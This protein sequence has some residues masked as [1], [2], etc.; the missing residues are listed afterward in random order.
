MK[1]LGIVIAF[2]GRSGNVLP[3]A[4]DYKYSDLA[5]K[6]TSISCGTATHSNTGF[7]ASQCSLQ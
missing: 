7:T 2:N 6:P 5:N 3:A 4:D 1:K